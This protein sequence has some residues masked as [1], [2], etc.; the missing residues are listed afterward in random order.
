ME[1]FMKINVLLTY[2]NNRDPKIKE[3]LLD[4][5]IGVNS[6]RRQILNIVTDA[7]PEKIT[8]QKYMTAVNKK[9]KFIPNIIVND[10]VMC[11]SENTSALYVKDLY[12][13]LPY[14]R[15]ILVFT[16]KPIDNYVPDLY[17]GKDYL[18]TIYVDNNTL[19]LI[20]RKSCCNGLLRELQDEDNNTVDEFAKYLDDEFEKRTNRKISETQS[21]LRYIEKFDYFL[22]TIATLSHA[23]DIHTANVLFDQH[24]NPYTLNDLLKENAEKYWTY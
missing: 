2:M 11:L 3:E 4:F 23:N 21:N 20:A 8:F 1:Q 14:Y 18:K 16:N 19:T 17:K 9:R 5:L 7:I 22:P 13:V 24:I 12:S 10:D 6:N 15:N